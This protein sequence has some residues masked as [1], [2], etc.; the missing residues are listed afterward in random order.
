MIKKKLKFYIPV[1]LLMV[2]SLIGLLNIE[3]LNS[4]Y[5]GYFNK[6]LYFYLG[7]IAVLILFKYINIDIIF[8]YSFVIYLLNIILLLLVLFFGKEVNGSRAWLLFNGVTIQPSEIM[9]LSLILYLSKFLAQIKFNEKTK[10]DFGTILKIWLIFLI[11]SILTF[12]EPDTGGVIIYLVIVFSLLFISKINYKWLLGIIGFMII[13]I[14]ALALVYYSNKEMFIKIFSSSMYYRIDR[15]LNF[16]NNMQLENALI[17][18]GTSGIFGHGIKSIP[19]YIIEA[20]TDFIFSLIIT[21]VGFI[22]GILLILIYI[23]MTKFFLD[24]LKNIKNLQYYYFV[25]G[26]LT[27]FLFQTIYSIMM[28]I[29]LLPI[30]GITLPLISYG[31]SSLVTFIVLFAIARN[32]ILSN[33]KVDSKV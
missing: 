27:I 31:G 33:S 23:I 12:L 8:K 30:M 13:I 5:S 10:K 20:P 17:N 29:G 22:G 18:I 3:T 9:K 28:N 24:N 32:I 21:K 11:P 19:L 15:L 26:V 14:L 25:F 6:Q 16:N 1:F 4:N 2:Y 7:T